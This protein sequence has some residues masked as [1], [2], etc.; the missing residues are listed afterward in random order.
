MQSLQPCSSVTFQNQNH[1][2]DQVQK[3][4]G[5]LAN[6]AKRSGASGEVPVDE[7]RKRTC[8]CWIFLSSFD[9]Y[10][11]CSRQQWDSRPSVD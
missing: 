5:Q 6:R 3:I 11:S 1:F 10:G 7:T 8:C 9:K 2:K 4:K